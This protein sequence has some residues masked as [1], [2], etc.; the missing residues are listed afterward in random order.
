MLLR[1]LEEKTFLPLG[2]DQEA[3]SD[4]QLIAGTNRNLFAAVRDGRFREDLF[5]RI[6]LWTFVMPGLRER[7]EDI[8][9]NLQFELEQHAEKTGHRVTFSK[10]ARQEFLKYALSPIAVWPGNFR[11]LNAAIARMAT[12]ALGARISVEIVQEEIDRLTSAWSERNGGEGDDP[13]VGLLTTD[14]LQK[15]DYF[16]RLQLSRVVDICRRSRSLSEAGRI[17]FNASRSRKTTSNDADRLR[18]YLTRFRLEWSQM[19]SGDSSDV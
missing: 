16:D 3:H 13:L 17:L 18:K 7:P 1:A 10:E 9:P 11:D 19:K 5:C 12:L 6:N 8:E 14:A 4:F 15:L 2:S